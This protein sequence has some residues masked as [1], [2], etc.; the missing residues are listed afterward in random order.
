MYKVGV[1]ERCQT[2]K[3]SETSYQVIHI[4]AAITER[5]TNEARMPKIRK[6]KLSTPNYRRE[7]QG[8]F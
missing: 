6:I 2:S 7:L 3:L 1:D 5:F 8:Q 4:I